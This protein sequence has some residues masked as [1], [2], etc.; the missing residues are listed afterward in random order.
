M[1]DDARSR[2]A[3]DIGVGV[4]GVGLE[5]GAPDGLHLCVVTPDAHLARSLNVQGPPEVVRAR[6]VPA[7]LH[8]IRQI[9]TKS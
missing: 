5:S 2:F 6:V 9:L 3:A 7:A 4:T 1:A 8:L